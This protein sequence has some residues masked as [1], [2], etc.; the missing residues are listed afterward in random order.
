MKS[1]T[2]IDLTKGDK[3]MNLISWLIIAALWILTVF[4][5]LKVT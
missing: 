1:G 3:I 5:Y 2:L 4:S